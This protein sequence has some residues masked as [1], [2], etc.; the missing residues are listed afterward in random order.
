M[1]PTPRERQQGLPPSFDLPPPR[2]LLSLIPV[3]HQNQFPRPRLSLLLPRPVL[4]KRAFLL[5]APFL[6]PALLGSIPSMSSPALSTAHPRVVYPCF[7]LL[8]IIVRVKYLHAS[9]YY[10]SPVKLT[11]PQ[12]LKGRRVSSWV[13]GRPGRRPT[14]KHV[15][16]P[17]HVQHGDELCWACPTRLGFL[18]SF[19]S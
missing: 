16:T 19:C 18:P 12:A 17:I 5:C 4:V 9:G 2:K 7:P 1:L 11:D 6:G 14:A 13:A 15:F 8:V 10:L 3:A